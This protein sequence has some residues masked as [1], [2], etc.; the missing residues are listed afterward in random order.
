MSETYWCTDCE[1]N[2]LYKSKI[3][4]RHLKFKQLEISN[5]IQ[6]DTND[7]TLAPGEELVGPPR[8]ITPET[9]SEEVRAEIEPLPP[10]EDQIAAGIRNDPYLNALLEAVGEVYGA[11]AGL[12]EQTAQALKD[13]ND[14][15]EYLR[16]VPQ[17]AGSLIDAADRFITKYKLEKQVQDTFAA[18]PRGIDRISGGDPVSS[19]LGADFL[20]QAKEAYLEREARKNIALG[21]LE[22]AMEGGKEVFL[23]SPEDA[24]RAREEGLIKGDE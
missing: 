16:N 12:E 15:I 9:W 24:E 13:I 23:L 11:V 1:R 14:S 17:G 7:I 8:E 22:A 4:H 21:K 2:H 20:E 19:G 6:S 3:G 5:D 10:T 18:V